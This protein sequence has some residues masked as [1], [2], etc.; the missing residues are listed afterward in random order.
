MVFIETEIK[1]GFQD[2][3]IRPKRSKL[4]S[5][6]DVDLMRTFKFLSGSTWTGVPIIAS[7][8][9]LSYMGKL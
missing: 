4:R 6:K 7:K 1:L 8:Y 5:R 2:V 3:L 9:N